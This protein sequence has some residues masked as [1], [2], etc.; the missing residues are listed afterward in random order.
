MKYN[1]L[2]KALNTIQSNEILRHTIV[3]VRSCFIKGFFLV[4]LEAK[5]LY[6]TF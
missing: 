1:T 6:E 4:Y 5:I 2:Y 3:K